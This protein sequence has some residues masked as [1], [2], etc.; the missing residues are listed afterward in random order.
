M[1]LRI[2]ASSA[3]LFFLLTVPCFAQGMELVFIGGQIL[4]DG[5]AVWLAADAVGQ[6]IDP[7]TAGSYATLPPDSH[8]VEKHGVD[9]YDAWQ[10]TA[11]TSKPWVRE[12]DCDK[13]NR[14]RTINVGNLSLRVTTQDGK[15][16]TAY[17]Y[18]QANKEDLINAL[19]R[20]GCIDQK[21]ADRLR[22]FVGHDAIGQD[23]P[24][25]PYAVNTSAAGPVKV[26]TPPPADIEAA[27]QRIA[28][29]QANRRANGGRYT[30]GK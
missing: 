19:L 26:G 2:A 25:L 29:T 3:V 30:G 15:P 6:P 20:D 14:I 11:D 23:P 8:A 9:A 1:K 12:Y 13:D 21:E 5:A 7:P 22:N 17:K 28:E 4:V 18:K 27:R 10:S 24:S 16:I